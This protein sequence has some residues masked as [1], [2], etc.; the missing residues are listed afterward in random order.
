MK[1]IFLMLI[2][3]LPFNGTCQLLQHPVPEPL[4][5]AFKRG[6][7]KVIGNYFDSK[8]ELAIIDDDD[9]VSKKQAE[10]KLK[11]FFI[12]FRPQNFVIVFEGGKDI[13][14]YAIG[15]LVTN[16]GEFRIVILL[17]NDKILQLRIEPDEN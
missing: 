11:E 1:I 4:K 3:T 16:N 14:Q 17:Q 2:L 8:I 7:V 5:Q 9:I 12:K 6:D 13:S 10:N 15:K